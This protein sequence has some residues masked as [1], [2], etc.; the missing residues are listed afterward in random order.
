MV[1]LVT[2]QVQKMR[3]M[4]ERALSRLTALTNMLCLWCGWMIHNLNLEVRVLSNR[5]TEPLE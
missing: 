5:T 4:T 2:R 3:Q 1:G